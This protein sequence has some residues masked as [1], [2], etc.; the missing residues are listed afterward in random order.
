MTKKTRLIKDYTPEQLWELEHRLMAQEIKRNPESQQLFVSVIA[1]IAG[2][3]KARSE[4][5]AFE[6]AS[7]EMGR[8]DFYQW[9]AENPLSPRA[10]LHNGMIQK[11]KDAPDVAL[12]LQ[13]SKQQQSFAGKSHA[14]S[15]EKHDQ[16]QQW[17]AEAIT[18]N[19][20]FADKSKSEQARL[21]KKKYSIEDKQGTIS[22]RLK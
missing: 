15:H 1:D 14:V 6:K 21:L 11:E 10:A 5:L 12:G 7:K 2:A 16:W 22:K 18:E 20:L 19:P 4:A 8:A 9:C 3:S 13:Y 17:Q